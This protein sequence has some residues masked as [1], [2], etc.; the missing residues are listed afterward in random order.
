RGLSHGQAGCFA[1]HGYGCG[2]D[3]GAARGTHRS[4]SRKRKESVMN[5]ELLIE[6]YTEELPPRALPELSAAFSREFCA[7]LASAGFIAADAKHRSFATPRRLAL[8]IPDVPGMSASRTETK[9]LMPA[10]VGFD[11]EGKPTAALAKRLE[12]DGVNPSST[13]LEKRTEGG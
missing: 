2:G 5:P 6:L 4:Q 9:K 1:R 7:E 10:K 3:A 11:A 8:L 13:K 12:K